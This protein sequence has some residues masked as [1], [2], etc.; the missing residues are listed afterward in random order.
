MDA[1]LELMDRHV[2]SGSYLTAKTEISI[3]GRE[4]EGCLWK[5]TT[6]LNRPHELYR[7]HII[8][9]PGLIHENMNQVV[10]VNDIETRIKLPF[11]PTSWAHIF[12]SLTQ[13]QTKYNEQELDSI[14]GEDTGGGARPAKEYLEQISM[15]QEVKSA[16]G[17]DLP[18]V[19]RGIIIWTFRKAGQ[20]ETGST[21][22]RY[23]SRMPPRSSCM[24]P[25][26]HPTQ[27]YT[28]NMNENLNSF[29]AGS[30]SLH[31]PN[32]LDSF[33]QSPLAF[34]S[35]IGL[36]SPFETFE[37]SFNHDMPMNVGFASQSI[38]DTPSTLENGNFNVENFLNN[39]NIHLGDFENSSTRWN[40]Q[41]DDSITADSSWSNYDGVLPNATQVEWQPGSESQW[42]TTSHMRQDIWTDGSNEKTGGENLEHQV[43]EP[44]KHTNW[45]ESA[46]HSPGQQDWKKSPDVNNEEKEDA[47]TPTQ[48]ITPEQ[49]WEL[50][51]QDNGSHNWSGT[52][53][54]HQNAEQD[55]CDHAFGKDL[56]TWVQHETERQHDEPDGVN[57]IIPELEA[58]AGW[59]S[60]NENYDYQQV[61]R[62][63]E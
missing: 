37:F 53:H 21:N 10:F 17:H 58:K 3:P 56:P 34:T 48:E 12:T 33:V 32:H 42:Q 46:G 19:R 9:P 7:D 14:Y 35:H 25:S 52:S 60:N 15:Y 41:H 5:T 39:G 36:Q 29:L 49:E 38:M 40:M 24:S 63:M 51:N 62:L 27:H 2:P 26:P 6:S 8:D 50:I 18:Y 23:I 16:R 22:W 31:Q 1:V 47:W 11:P 55:H 45:D 28:A 59:E 61:E 4:L 54:S 43:E 57:T 13:L 30:I 20:G 44:I